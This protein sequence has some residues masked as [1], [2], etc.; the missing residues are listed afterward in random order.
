MTRH[1]KGHQWSCDLLI[2]SVTMRLCQNHI[3]STVD[4]I[5][6]KLEQKILSVTVCVGKY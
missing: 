5:Y 1:V 4:N 2:V 6:D 3:E